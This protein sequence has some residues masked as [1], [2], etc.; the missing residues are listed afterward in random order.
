MSW[1]MA[2][3]DPEWAGQYEEE[4]R[5]LRE[6]FGADLVSLHHVG[7]TA[8]PGIRA[9]PIIDIVIVLVDISRIHG[10]DGAMVALGYRPR[11]ECLRDYLNHMTHPVDRAS[12]FY[13]QEIMA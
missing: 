11:G 6:V 8:V 1:V 4:A 13:S 12:E 7:S 3:H 9:K 5:H 10:F 2:P